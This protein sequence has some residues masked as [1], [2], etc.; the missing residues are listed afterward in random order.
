LVDGRDGD[1]WIDGWM[2][3]W[4]WELDEDARWELAIMVY[5]VLGEC[6][7]DS[8]ASVLMDAVVV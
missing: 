4:R 2:D 3:E 8:L 7:R 1:G 6:C 5:V